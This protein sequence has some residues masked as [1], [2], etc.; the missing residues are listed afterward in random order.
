MG[1]WWWFE[2]A[3]VEKVFMWR[4]W[5]MKVCGGAYTKYQRVMGCGDE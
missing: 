4:E 2:G 1:W 5:L 3:V